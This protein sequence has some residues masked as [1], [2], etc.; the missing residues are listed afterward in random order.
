MPHQLADLIRSQTSSASPAINGYAFTRLQG[1]GRLTPVSWLS[2][3]FE[4]ASVFGGGALAVS[5]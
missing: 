4:I 5:R 2:A 3:A 1:H